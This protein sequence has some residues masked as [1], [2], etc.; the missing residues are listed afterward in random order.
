MLIG[1]TSLKKSLRG[2]PFNSNEESTE[3]LFFDPSPFKFSRAR[4]TVENLKEG[5]KVPSP[6]EGVPETKQSGNIPV[7]DQVATPVSLPKTARQDA[8]FDEMPNDPESLLD[9]R[10]PERDESI[11]KDVQTEIVQGLKNEG[12]VEAEDVHCFLWDFAG[13]SVY[14][15]THPLFLTSRGIYLLFNDLS[16]NPLEKAKPHVKQGMYRK[17]LD[18]SGS[19]T[20]FDYLDFWMSST[21]SLANW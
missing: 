8:R 6:E 19:K 15:T 20:N 10:Y 21:A 7:V 4:A 16:Q 11:P 1:Q 12:K 3:G 18:S 5:K 2:E 13:Q 9:F 14:Y 17:L